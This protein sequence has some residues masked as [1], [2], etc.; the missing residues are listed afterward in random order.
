MTI[1]TKT[2]FNGKII[3]VR[4]NIVKEI[5]IMNVKINLTFTVILKGEKLYATQFRRR[6]PQRRKSQQ[7]PSQQQS[8]QKFRFRQQHQI[9]QKAVQKFK[10]VQIL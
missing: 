4:A 3:A 9:F 8:Q 5:T 1:L 2:A 10:K 6:K 7:Q